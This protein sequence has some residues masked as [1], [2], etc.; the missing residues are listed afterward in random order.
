MRPS[1]AVATGLDHIRA[2]VHVLVLLI[3]GDVLPA[4]SLGKRSPQQLGLPETVCPATYHQSPR[5]QPNRGSGL[6]AGY[7]VPKEHPVSGQLH[8]ET[9]LSIHE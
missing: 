6:L 9:G 8:V 5:S 7:P 3:V 2:I 4:T 1:Y